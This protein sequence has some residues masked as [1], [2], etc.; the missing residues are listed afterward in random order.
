MGSTNMK[1]S[2]FGRGQFPA[3][4]SRQQ[5]SWKM[6]HGA[7]GALRKCFIRPLRDFR[8]DFATSSRPPKVSSCGK[9]VRDSEEGRDCMSEEKQ[10]E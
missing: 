3:R 2:D 6:S 8:N 5:H 1:L 7:T 9:R 4:M 10:L